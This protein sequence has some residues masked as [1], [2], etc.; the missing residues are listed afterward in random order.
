MYIKLFLGS[1]VGGIAGA[2]QRVE[3]LRWAKTRLPGKQFAA[4]LD[5]DRRYWTTAR[6]AGVVMKQPE[7]KVAL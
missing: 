2:Q 3:F 1:V 5:L 4:I 6:M 7:A